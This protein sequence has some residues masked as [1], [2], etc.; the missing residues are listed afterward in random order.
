MSNWE[1]R[2]LRSVVI[3]TGMN[4]INYT[5]HT[6]IML[7]SFFFLSFFISFFFSLVQHSILASSFGVNRL[8]L[9]AIPDQFCVF[10]S[11]GILDPGQFSNS[12][13]PTT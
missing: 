4:A 8:H 10:L 5:L 6:M 9:A 2:D 3:L 1:R 13:K 7:L 12:L 11:S